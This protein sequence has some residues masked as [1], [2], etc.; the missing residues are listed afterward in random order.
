MFNRSD[1]N[2][3]SSWY[4]DSTEIRFF[5]DGEGEVTFGDVSI[6]EGLFDAWPERKR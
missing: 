5:H 2:I 6:Y 1:A 4:A 3:D